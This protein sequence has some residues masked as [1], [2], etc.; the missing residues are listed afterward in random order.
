MPVGRAVRDTTSRIAERTA[1]ATSRNVAATGAEAIPFWGIAVIVAATAY[2]LKVAC[3]T[4]RD[5]H[6]L[7]LAFDPDAALDPE[8]S[9]ACGAEVP[10]A[11]EIWTQ[12]AASPAAAAQAARAAY[13]DLPPLDLPDWWGAISARATALLPGAPAVSD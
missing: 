2:E 8:R 11:S 12:V 1:I 7:D 4:M 10:T 3:D 5:L 13:D 6:E 9:Q